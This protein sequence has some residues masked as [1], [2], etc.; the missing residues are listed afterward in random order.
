MS[1]FNANKIFLAFGLAPPP[2]LMRMVII[3]VT[4]EPLNL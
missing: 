3:V 4:S 2:S 1:Q